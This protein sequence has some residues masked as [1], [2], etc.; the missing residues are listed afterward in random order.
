MKRKAIGFH[1][2][3][4]HQEALE[5]ELEIEESVK[6]LKDYTPNSRVELTVEA[7]GTPGNMKQIRNSAGSPGGT[8]SFGHAIG[9]AK[10]MVD[11]SLYDFTAEPPQE[12]T[13]WS[14]TGT[15][16]KE[17]DLDSLLALARNEGYEERAKSFS[18][19]LEIITLVVVFSG[20]GF[21]G[22]LTWIVTH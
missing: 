11:T 19:V 16:V 18:K 1:A 20:L 10:G 6:I 4:I 5:R 22:L 15:E 7:T 8:K 2:A 21:I 3:K 9:S 13:Y 14:K 17:F 12:T